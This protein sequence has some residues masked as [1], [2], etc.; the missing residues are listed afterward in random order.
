MSEFDLSSAGFY[1]SNELHAKEV[2]LGDETGV[3]FVRKLPALDLRRW[4]EEMK[5]PEME[6]RINAGF[7]I[8]AKSIRRE[9]GKPHMTFEQAQK[10]KPEAVAEL[11]RVFVD[12]NKLPP[13]EEAGND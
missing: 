3:V 11:M 4:G 5:D 6:V 1:S 10:L 2:K 13:P 12:V 9:D 7:R 8:L